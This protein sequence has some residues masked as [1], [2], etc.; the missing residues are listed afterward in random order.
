MNTSNLNTPTGFS[1]SEINAIEAG[2]ADWNG[3]PNSSDI[4]YIFFR[5]PNPPA[6]PA[7]HAVIV[8]FSPPNSSAAAEVQ[9]FSHGPGSGL[10]VYNVMTFHGNIRVG[11]PTALF[12]FVRALARHE[13]S[14]TLGLNNSNC[15]NS[16]TY[17]PVTSSNNISPCDNQK[18]NTQPQYPPTSCPSCPWADYSDCPSN[19]VSHIDYCLYPS[20]GCPP[21]IGVMQ[22]GACWCYRPSPVLV[23]VL[24]NGFD[25]TDA[26]NGVDFDINADGTL[27]RISWTAVGDDA[28][29]AIDLNGN[30]VI[31]N[32]TE[33]FGTFSPQPVPPAGVEKNGFLALAEY[34]KLPAGGN[35]D[36]Q[37]TASDA[38][39]SQLRLWQ[40]LNHN[41]VSEPSELHTL[42]EFGLATLEL[43]YK[44][45]KKTD[46]HGNQLR[47]RAKVK[48]V[49]GR[50][51]G[52]WAWDVFLL[53]QQ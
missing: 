28:W 8:N 26:A 18:I 16:V 51:I 42:I 6:L 32:G 52:R 4:S 11:D 24:G 36:G 31:D 46:E 27:E 29:L 13:T 10:I 19:C 7:T 9:T 43:R 30:G 44:E 3:Q 17:I 35:L 21:V 48:D 38:A 47:Y 20:T 12:D 5:T 41:G 1:Q 45:S 39:F 50:Q 23:D 15:I 53:G 37:I 34:D 40:D 25:L 22:D 49:H 2:I 14:H 33:V